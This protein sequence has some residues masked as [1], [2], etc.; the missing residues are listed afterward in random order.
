MR[1]SF[2]IIA[3]ALAALP[4]SAQ[5]KSG[6]EAWQDP[7]LFEENRM[8]MRASFVQTPFKDKVFCWSVTKEIGRA[9]V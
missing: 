3:A 4:C 8:P 6:L 7:N 5:K 9:H 1:N 2:L